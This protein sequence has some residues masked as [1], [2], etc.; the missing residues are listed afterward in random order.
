MPIHIQSTVYTVLLLVVGLTS[1]TLNIIGVTSQTIVHAQGQCSVTNATYNGSRGT[2]SIRN[3][4]PGKSYG[5]RLGPITQYGEANSSGTVNITFDTMGTSTGEPIYVYKGVEGG[6][7]TAYCSGA[8]APGSGEVT[9]SQLTATF[10][11]PITN[12]EDLEEACLTNHTNSAIYNSQQCRNY[13]NNNSSATTI[14]NGPQDP[15]AG[16]T[17]AAHT[18][19]QAQKAC[20]TTTNREAGKVFARAFNNACVTLPE[21]ITTLINYVMMFASVIAGFMFLQGGIKI[22][23]SRGN[24]TAVVEARSTLLHAAIGLV[25]LATSY[26]IINFLN[27][28]ISGGVTPD[29]NLLGPFVPWKSILA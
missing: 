20:Q 27:G 9:F 2:V 4:D 25:L 19:C 3:A 16:K 14:N 12:D 5:V 24:P 6:A 28:A 26:V 1:L 11:P 21:F 29:I 15:C 7:P 18:S 17:G 13:R 8:S 22:I 10:Q 23:A